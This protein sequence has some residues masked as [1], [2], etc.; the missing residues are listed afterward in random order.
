MGTSFTC[1]L[2]ATLAQVFCAGRNDLGQLGTLDSV[3]LAAPA[4]PVGGAAS[5]VTNVVALSCAAFF[6]NALRGDGSVVSWG[7][8]QYGQCGRTNAAGML[9][10]GV[11]PSPV[12][13]AS[14]SSGAQASCGISVAANGSGLFC[15]GSAGQNFVNTNTAAP[16]IVTSVGWPGGMYGARGVA[17]ST[18]DNGAVGTF[19]L[20]AVAVDAGGA[21]WGW[22]HA[23]FR[24]TGY[25]DTTPTWTYSLGVGNFNGGPRPLCWNMTGGGGANVSSAILTSSVS[26]AHS[27]GQC[28]GAAGDW[29]CWGTQSTRMGRGAAA[30]NIIPGSGNTWPPVAVPSSPTGNYWKTMATG[31]SSSCGIDAANAMY[32]WG[33]LA[34]PNSG[35]LFTNT[36][37]ALSYPTAL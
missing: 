8:C 3:S 10:P 32:C 4:V 22:G 6:C 23:L 37:G 2:H 9:L 36:S 18:A 35:R 12:G 28:G 14:I 15:W 19:G 25:C 34:L 16:Q 1:A 26:S 27:C 17:L 24:A 29:L 30:L 11:V 7:Y 31:S 13:F 5:P 20:T 33:T 21:V